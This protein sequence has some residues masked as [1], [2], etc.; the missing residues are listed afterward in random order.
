MIN[1]ESGLYESIVFTII[2][3][4][5]TK[6]RYVAG[7][8]S[9]LVIRQKR[10]S[11]TKTSNFP[12]N[13]HFLPPDST[14]TCAYQGVRNACFSENLMGFVFLKHPF[15]DSPFCLITDKL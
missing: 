8:R 14:R 3:Q 4:K 9:S 2:K 15:S 12:K 11:Q 1:G 7:T 6:G 5:Q 13:E 10:E